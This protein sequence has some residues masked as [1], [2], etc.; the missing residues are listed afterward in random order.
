[1]LPWTKKFKESQSLKNKIKKLLKFPL[2]LGKPCPL[3]GKKTCLEW[4]ILGDKKLDVST[5]LAIFDDD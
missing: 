5:S 4:L 3:C 2:R 1:M